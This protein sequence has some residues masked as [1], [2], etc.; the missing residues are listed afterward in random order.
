MLDN[1]IID[2]VVINSRD[3]TDRIAREREL[4]RTNQRL[5][6]FAGVISHDLQTPLGIAQTY[7]Q[8]A[9]RSSSGTTFRRST[10]HTNEWRR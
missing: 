3:V 10:T 2:R 1:G 7:A 9:E 8:F 5:D 4:E 6:E